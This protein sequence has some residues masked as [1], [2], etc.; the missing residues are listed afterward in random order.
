VLPLAFVLIARL[1][2]IPRRWAGVLIFILIAETLHVAPNFLTFFNVLAGG[3]QRGQTILNDSNFDWGTG[4]LALRDWMRDHHVEKVQLGYFGRVDPAI[5][6]IK[7]DLLTEISGAPF[8]AISSHYVVGLPYRLPG[9]N[10]PSGMIS[11]PFHEQLRRQPRVGVI[12]GGT[13]NIFRREDVARA[14]QEFQSSADSRR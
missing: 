9:P 5:Y 3:P 2:M 1:T 12:A 8:V 14:M 13:I 7:Y 6:G 11:L 10:G 4:L